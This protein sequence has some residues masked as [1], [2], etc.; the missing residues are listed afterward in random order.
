MTVLLGVQVPQE[1]PQAVSDIVVGALRRD[2]KDR[3][4][5]QEI[6]C[7]IESSMAAQTPDPFADDTAGT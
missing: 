3:P 2:P 7:V 5:A 4:T 6:I 1:C